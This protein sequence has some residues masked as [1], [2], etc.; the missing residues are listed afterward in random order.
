M[1]GLWENRV[2]GLANLFIFVSEMQRP[3]ILASALRSRKQV[4]YFM[5]RALTL[6]YE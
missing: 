1:R 4:T 2:L 3:V 6:M 5:L